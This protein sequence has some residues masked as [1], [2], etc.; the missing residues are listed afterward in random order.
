MVLRSEVFDR[1]FLRDVVALLDSHLRRLEFQAGGAED[2]ECPGLLDQWDYTAGLGF[3]AF[4]TYTNAVS[5]RRSRECLDFGRCHRCGKSFARLANE[6]ANYWKHKDQWEGGSPHPRVQE[7]FRA[8]G[9]N[10][11]DAH[12]IPN[13]YVVSNALAAIVSPLPVALGTVVPFL[14]Q[15]AEAVRSERTA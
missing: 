4:Q 1:Q 12:G 15:W 13:A 6:I 7:A 14:E 9:V 10:L 8:L 11:R 3:A 5:G 2:P